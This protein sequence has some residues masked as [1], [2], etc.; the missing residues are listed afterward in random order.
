MPSILNEPW[1]YILSGA[2][3]LLIIVLGS[4]QVVWIY[5]QPILF[6]RLKL[7]DQKKWRLK[8]ELFVLSILC[9]CLLIIWHFELNRSLLHTEIFDFQLVH[10]FNILSIFQLA[11]IFDI[12]FAS[13]FPQNFYG[14]SFSARQPQP[15]LG[16]TMRRIIYLLA[17][18]FALSY[19]D[20]N[21]SIFH[22]ST[23]NGAID[24]RI[25]RILSAVLILLVAR[26]IVWLITHV[27]LPNYYYRK[28]ISTGQQ[29]ALN[30]LLAYVIYTFAIILAINALSANVTLLLGGTAALLVGVGLGLQDIFKDVV[31]G[32]VLLSER[33]I[34]VGDVVETEQ[35]VGTVQKIG[36]RSSQ[37]VAKDNIVLLVPNSNLT[38]Q[39]VVNWSNVGNK[40]RF[41]LTVGIA[42]GSDVKDAERCLLES[43]KSHIDILAEPTPFIRFKD[44]AD[45]ALDLR[46]AFLDS[47]AFLRGRH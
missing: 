35:S 5:L 39:N 12:L 23:E 21:F 6:D 42:Y 20:I 32:I 3:L 46:T 36:L 45:S 17:L 44:F 26:I 22:I 2:L 27:V 4:Y 43:A 31:S 19:F 47:S 16:R 24:F 37:I 38:G 18:M 29:F 34:R 10:I 13:G 7:N 40:A 14:K 30:S 41:V 1:V 28:G 15:M 33:N 25:N 9:Y 11:R 8:L